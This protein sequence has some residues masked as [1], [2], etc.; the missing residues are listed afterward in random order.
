MP[1]IQTTV[2]GSY[3]IPDWLAAMPTEQALTDATRVVLPTF[4]GGG[5]HVN[6][7]GVV[8]TKHAPNKANATKLIE[9]LVGE[10]AQHMYADMNYEYPLRSDVAV[11]ATIAGYGKLKPDP[12][13]LAKIAQHR[14]QAAALVDK[15]GFDQ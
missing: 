6:L 4:Q 12:V 8:L 2:V 15:V 5:T 14:K 11:N 10:K 7:S 9:W 13:P 3:P 1:R